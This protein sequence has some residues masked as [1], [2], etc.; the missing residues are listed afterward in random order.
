MR[1]SR[2]LAP[3]LGV[4]I[5]AFA[6]TAL[7][8]YLSRGESELALVLSEVTGHVTLIDLDERVIEA[9]AGAEISPL[10]RVATGDNARAVLALGRDTRIRL[11]PS[12]SV[13]VKGIDAVGVHLEL[14]DGALEATVR[15]TSGALQVTS[16]TRE[17]LATDADLEVGVREG[18]LAFEVGHGEAVLVGVQ[19]HPTLGPGERLL[20]GEADPVRRPLSDDLL[21][22]VDWPDRTTR[23]ATVPVSG[24]TE[25]GAL[26]RATGRGGTV[27]VVA[28]HDGAFSVQVPLEEGSNDLR[29]ESTGILGAHGEADGEVVKDTR[30]PGFGGAIEYIS[31]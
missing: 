8:T 25:P 4:V 27:E 9:G 26:V 30:G 7:W 16:G 21:L 15:P 28:G 17:I 12:S 23:D 22:T 10:Q 13:Q 5:V 31:P 6:A 20:V 19:G 29:V 11:G 14:E 24:S 18:I 1:D 3:L 2:W